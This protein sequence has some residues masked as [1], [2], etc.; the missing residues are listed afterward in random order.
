MYAKE[1]KRNPCRYHFDVNSLP[2][3]NQEEHSI[4]LGSAVVGISLDDRIVIHQVTHKCQQWN[5]IQILRLA[6]LSSSQ[7]SA[8]SIRVVSSFQ[9]ATPRLFEKCQLVTVARA[10]R[11]L[12][13]ILLQRHSHNHSP[14]LIL[15]LKNNLSNSRNHCGLWGEAVMP[16]RS[17]TSWTLATG[18][19]CFRCWRKANSTRD[20]ISLNVFTQV[21]FH[22]QF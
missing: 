4:G 13:P 10:P 21:S 9:H 12:A 11:G 8:T 18:R 7:T 6:K 16:P 1:K 22:C 14:T 5:H 19:G 20:S 17:T 15:F 2:M 3:V